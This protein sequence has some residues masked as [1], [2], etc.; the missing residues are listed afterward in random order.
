MDA[1]HRPHEEGNTVY[2]FGGGWE[3]V[4]LATRGRMRRLPP[5]FVRDAVLVRIALKVFG[6][7]LRS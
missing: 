2:S 3:L 1:V 7:G 4:L 5:S 6:R